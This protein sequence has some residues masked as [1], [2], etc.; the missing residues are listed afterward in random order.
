MVTVETG[1]GLQGSGVGSDPKLLLRVSKD[2]GRTWGAW[3]EGEVGRAGEYR[4][5]VAFRQL[6]NAS[7]FTFEFRMTD[8]VPFTLIDAQ[9]EV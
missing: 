8:P 1:V 7:T 4:K 3:R 2:M 5:T 9:I 6:G